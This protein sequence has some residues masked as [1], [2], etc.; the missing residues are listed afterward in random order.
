MTTAVTMFKI[1]RSFSLYPPASLRLDTEEAQRH[2]FPQIK[3]NNYNRTKSDNNHFPL[4]L[5]A[6][7]KLSLLKSNHHFSLLL[8]PT[9]LQVAIAV[10]R[11][12]SLLPI[13][14]QLQ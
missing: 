4:P 5:K 8:L 10:A 9:F 11:L 13:T 7:N 1:I 6:F 2:S 12:F 3:L 14:H